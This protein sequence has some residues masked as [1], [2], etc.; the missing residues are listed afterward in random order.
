[1]WLA[2]K[3]YFWHCVDYESIDNLIVRHFFILLFLYTALGLPGI[4]YFPGKIIKNSNI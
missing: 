1:M 3:K 2:E 4:L